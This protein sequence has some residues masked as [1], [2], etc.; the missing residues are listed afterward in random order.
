VHLWL[1][2]HDQETVNTNQASSKNK[3]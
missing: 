1:K 2:K 3:E